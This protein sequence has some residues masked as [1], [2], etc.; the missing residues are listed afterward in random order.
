VLVTLLACAPPDSL[1]ILPDATSAPLL[2]DFVAFLDDPRVSVGEGKGVEV[3]IHADLDCTECYEISAEG[4]AWVVH[5]GAP[6]GV[7]YGLAD[8]LEREGYGFFHPYETRRP[9][10]FTRPDAMDPERHDPVVARRGVHLHTLHPIEALAALWVPNDTDEAGRIVDWVVK[11]RG[12]HVQWPALDDIQRDDATQV[13]WE[14]HTKRIVDGAHARG[15]TVG[16]GVQLFGA[17]NLQQAF[18]LLD[19]VGTAEEQAATM[20]ERLARLSGVDWDL[21]NL[22]FGEFFGQDPDTFIASTNLAYARIQ[23]AMPG[24]EVPATIHVGN[25]ADLYVTYQGQEMLYYFLV[26]FADPGILPWIHT[27]M[28][29][30]LYE[31]AGGAYQHETF[32]AHREFLEERLAAGSPVGYFPETAYWVAFDNPVPQYLPL[33]L[34]SRSVDLERLIP[35]GLQDHVVFSTGWEWGYWQGDVVSLRM[36]YDGVP[37]TTVVDGMFDPATAGMVE[38]VAEAQH[39]GLLEGRLAAYTAGRD[40]IIDAGDATGITSQ[41]DRPS[42][43]DVVAMAP[44]DRATFRSDVVDGL[45]AL[46]EAEERATVDPVD[47]WAAEI[48]DGADVDVLR[49]RFAAATWGA[50]VTFADGGDPAD[51]LAA[52]DAALDQAREVVARREAAFHDPDGERWTRQKWSNPTIY[53]YGY[54]REASSLCF[55]ER[56]RAQARNLVLQEDEVVPACIF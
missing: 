37:W 56:E 16:V 17:S 39:E 4:R 45:A 24:V 34:R 11:N 27:V 41:P 54:L 20:D 30:D 40:A 31:D 47:S 53:D 48:A 12:N 38:G 6:L 14:A 35:Q 15:V 25:Y 23:A 51:E 26:Q 13:A 46:A 2:G 18:D 21:V 22:S 29:Y 1:V 33:Y 19:T 36:S 50:V 7:Q 44:G 49:A 9:D 43:E 42:F 8:V 10:H 32:D 52:A 3:E 55:W 5:G 28:Y